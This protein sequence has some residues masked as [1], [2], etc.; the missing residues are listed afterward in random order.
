MI[1]NPDLT[2]TIEELDQQIQR[3]YPFADKE[4]VIFGSAS[5]ILRGILDRPAGDLDVF[6]T[7]KL[8]GALLA[9]EDWHVETPKATHPPI[10]V[11]DTTPVMIHAFYDWS[12]ELCIMEPQKLIKD[13]EYA[14]YNHWVYPVVSV[15][16]AL[17]VKIDAA[18]LGGH[19]KHL[20]DIKV[21][22]EWLAS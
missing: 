22:Q 17:R 1:I 2:V 4:Y 11:N 10:L 8:W 15:D 7:R 21:I 12:N 13:R 19:V 6:M 3:C 14:W 9:N 16:E 20:P 5:L 18:E